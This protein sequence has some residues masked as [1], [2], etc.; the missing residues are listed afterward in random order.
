MYSRIPTS[1]LIVSLI[2]FSLPSFADDSSTNDQP[3]GWSAGPG[4]VG[5]GGERPNHP[6]G[7]GMPP[8]GGGLLGPD[9]MKACAVAAGV[10]F[11]QGQKPEI[12]DSQ[13]SQIKSCMND[14]DSAM[15]SCLSA[16]GVSLPNPPQAGQKPDPSSMPKLDDTTKQ[17]IDSCRQQVLSGNSGSSGSSTA[18]STDTSTDTN[19]NS[20]T[21]SSSAVRSAI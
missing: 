12:S 2:T 17:A 8:R 4:G 18:T 3:P 1:L 20:D 19:T 6:Q 15:K 5:D 10:S 7:H 14:K 13:K 11:S 16:A 21:D 9:A